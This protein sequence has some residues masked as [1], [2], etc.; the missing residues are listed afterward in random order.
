MLIYAT[1]AELITWLGG[2][3]PANAT[4]LLRSA[5]LLVRGA[6]VA[7]IYGTDT[8]GLPTDATVRQA[9]KDAT[10]AQAAMWSAAGIDPA[11]GGVASSAPVRSKKLGSGSVDY[12]TSVNASVTAFTAKQA[13]TTSLCAEAWLLLKQA[14]L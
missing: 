3:A 6:T 11:G 4:T 5:S 1:A 9:F 13:A 7:S 10:C 8:A 2:P 14:G 12:D